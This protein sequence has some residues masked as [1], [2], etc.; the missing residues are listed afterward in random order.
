MLP[1]YLA[2]GYSSDD[3]TFFR[4]IRKLMPGHHLTL[5]LNTSSPAPQI[6]QYWDIPDPRP[7]ERDD[8]AAAREQLVAKGVDA[9][10]VETLPWGLFV[11]FADPDGNTWALQQIVR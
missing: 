10:E 7:E 2:F 8:A 9:S 11:R 4:G 5:D 1:E 3:R 6:R